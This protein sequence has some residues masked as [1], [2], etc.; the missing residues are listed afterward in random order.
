MNEKRK[1]ENGASLAVAGP[2]AADLTGTPRLVV[3]VAVKR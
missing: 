1:R 3:A 2:M